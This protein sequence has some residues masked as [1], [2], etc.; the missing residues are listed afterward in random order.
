[1]TMRRLLLLLLLSLGQLPSVRAEE[2][3]HDPDFNDPGAAEPPARERYVSPY[4]VDFTFSREELLSDILHGWRGEAREESSFEHKHWDSPEVR[5]RYGAWGPPARHYPPPEGVRER[6][7]EWR[8]ERVIAV[9]L[10]FVGY[11]YQHHHIPDWNPPVDW[12]WLKAPS[13]HNG[14]G[15]DCS[16][17]TAFVYNQA[18]GIKLNGDIKI[19]A[20]EHRVK[21]FCEQPPHELERIELPPRYEDFPNVLRTGDLLYLVRK[22]GEAY[23]V[24]IWIGK[25]G[26]APDGKALL[27]DSTGVVRH[28]D[29]NGVTVPEGI[30]LRPFDADS[31]YF[32]T[33]GHAL[34]IIRD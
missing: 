18:L 9:A 6:S 23:H 31:R 10:R 24:V 19:Q 26:R 15:V 7:A 25:L 28:R 21:G 34:R 13:G 22:N 27:L 29:A 17:F 32:K 20:R 14:K 11:S 12:P 5:R 8:R 2:P 33:A 1:M 30:Y 4:G 3:W 16:N